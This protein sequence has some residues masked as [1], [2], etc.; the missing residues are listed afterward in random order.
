[1]AATKDLSAE[2]GVENACAT[3]AVPRASYYR[4]HDDR[5][6]APPSPRPTPA[7]AL[8]VGE[9]DKVLEVLNSPRFVD[10]SPREIYAT[11]LDEKEYHCSVRTMYRILE[12]EG[13]SR[14]RRDQLRHPIYTKPELLAVGP[15]QVW[16]WDITKLRGPV[17]WK[18]YHLYVIIDIFS[19]YVVGWMV[20]DRED[21]G[22]AARLIRETCLKQGVTANQLV[23][24]S[25]RGTSMT[26]HTVSQLLASLGVIKSHSRPHVSDD[27]AYSEAQFK[28]LKYRPDFPETFGS[29]EDAR[30]FLR[31]FFGWYNEQHHHDGIGLLTPS[32]V[33]HGKAASILKARQATLDAAYRAHPE[34]FVKRAPVP[35]QLPKEVWI[36][37]P[38]PVDSL[39]APSHEAE[40]A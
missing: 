15:N 5:V 27:N 25:D 34:R 29:I 8:T 38:R 2:V 11:L 24:H 4:H 35:N 21:A 18:Y 23:I 32:V 26:S 9:R 1:M 28:T 39:E 33:H 30:A 22:L 16:S 7:R 17:K 12:D 19:R 36:N 40:V 3:L 37:K 20:A 10:R 13:A 31:D 6:S 14:E